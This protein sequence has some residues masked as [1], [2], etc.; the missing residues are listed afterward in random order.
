MH[1]DRQLVLLLHGPVLGDDLYE[2]HEVRFLDCEIEVE[3]TLVHDRQRLAPLFVDIDVAHVYQ[4]VLLNLNDLVLKL[5][6]LVHLIPDSLDVERNRSR[7][8][9]QVAQNIEIKRLFFFWCESDIND[10]VAIGPNH[11]AHG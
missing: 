8:A 5:D 3:I 4:R 9:L 7:L 1:V 6:G 11:P 10:L 2:V